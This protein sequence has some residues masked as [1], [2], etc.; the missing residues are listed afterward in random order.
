MLVYLVTSPVALAGSSRNG[1]SRRPADPIGGST[2]RVMA[3]RTESSAN[4]ENYSDV[5]L[6]DSAERRY[7]TGPICSDLARLLPRRHERWT[8]EQASSLHSCVSPQR[9][10]TPDSASTG[11]PRG[12]RG[13]ARRSWGDRSMKD[14]QECVVLRLILLLIFITIVMLVGDAFTD[15]G[16][17][18]GVQRTVGAFALVLSFIFTA[19]VLTNIQGRAACP[20]CGARPLPTAP[21]WHPGMPEPKLVCLECLWR[22]GRL[23]IQR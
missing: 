4:H 1:C 12:R 5:F 13:W 11:A 2:R 9:G 6:N 18:L 19:M 15:D 8:C 22:E 21:T 14:R 3:R 17:P 7:A 20:E 23:V 10:Y 16:P